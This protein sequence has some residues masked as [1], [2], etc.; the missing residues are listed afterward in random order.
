MNK[1]KK[2]LL[3]FSSLLSAVCYAAPVPPSPAD[4]LLSLGYTAVPIR[5]VANGF[6]APS[7][8]AVVDASIDNKTFYPFIIDTGSTVTTIDINTAQ[9]NQFKYQDKSTTLGGGDSQRHKA[10][11]V[12][13]SQLQVNPFTAKDILAYTEYDYRY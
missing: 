8:T 2:I 7:V 12:L 6:S 9:A 11:Q 1:I 3:L 10:N 13:I 4:L 5:F